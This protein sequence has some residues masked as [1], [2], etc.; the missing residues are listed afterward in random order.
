MVN[1]IS[2]HVNSNINIKSIHLDF[3]IF[4]GVLQPD[5]VL[6]TPEC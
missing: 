4:Y 3:L 5:F 2:R 6:Y 1:G